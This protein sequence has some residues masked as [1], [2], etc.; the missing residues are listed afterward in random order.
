MPVIFV[1]AH[2]MSSGCSWAGLGATLGF[3]E[4]QEGL[5][6][7]KAPPFNPLCPSTALGHFNHSHLAVVLDPVWQEDSC[8][9]WDLSEW[10]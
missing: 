3:W 10:G 9:C 4:G 1:A 7:S 5:C 2:M 8:I 6:G